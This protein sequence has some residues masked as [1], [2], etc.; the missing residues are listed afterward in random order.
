MAMNSI[1]E[2]F[3]IAYFIYC[4]L[5]T[6]TQLTDS[7]Q[8]T[9]PAITSEWELIRVRMTVQKAARKSTFPAVPVDEDTLPL[10]TT[11][12]TTRYLPN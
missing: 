4:T 8:S 10:E 5:D 1:M 9:S 2:N 12:K 3:H 6:P 11:S 7:K